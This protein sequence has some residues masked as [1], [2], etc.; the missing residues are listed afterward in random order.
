MPL[1]VGQL[2]DSPPGSRRIGVSGTA[3]SVLHSEWNVQI[4]VCRQN[5][6]QTA[7][8]QTDS[9]F[10]MRAQL[11][12]LDGERPITLANDVTLVGRKPGMCDLIVDRSS[13]SKLHSV[14]DSAKAT[15]PSSDI[16]LVYKLR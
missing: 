2:L 7:G 11:I 16:L 14:L 9:E 3:P 8:F 15:A 12:P 4:P 6:G 5:S 1:S 13:V 10:C